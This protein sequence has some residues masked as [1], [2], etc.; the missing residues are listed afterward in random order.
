MAHGF[1]TPQAVSGESPISKYFEKKVDQLI[2]KGVKKIEN[3]AK[4]K[5]NQFKDLFSKKR[6]TTY[7]SGR[8][9]V[10]VAGR[11]GIGENTA[12]GGGILGGSPKV[13]GILPASGGLA[14]SQEN[15]IAT[16]GKNGTDLDNKFFRQKAL[17]TSDPEKPGNRPRK[18]GSYV[19]MGGM[20]SGDGLVNKTNELFSKYA[21]F[22]QEEVLQL[23]KE[24]KITASELRELK[25]TVQAQ[26]ASAAPSVSPDS[27]A[28]VVAAVN[29]NTE[30]IMRMVEVT[31]AQTS[32]DSSLVKEQIQAQE[33]MLSRSKARAEETQLEKGSD[34]SD[35]LKA[36]R[37]KKKEK[38]QGGGGGDD[39]LF[40]FL[41][42]A[43]DLFDFG[44]GGGKRKGRRGGGLAR[45]G[46]RRKAPPRIRAPRA[47]GGAPRI[48]T[49]KPSAPR[50]GVPK[51]GL[52]KIRGGPK[53][54]GALSLLFAGMEFSGRKSDGQSNIQAGLGT[55]ASV[56]GGIAGAKGGAAAGAAIG[57]LFGGVGAIPGGIIGGILGGIGGSMLAG[58]AADMAT[59]AFA[60]GG[61]ISK[62]I[63]SLMG[64]G[65]KKEGVFP[66]EGSEGK[67][68][69]QK[70]GEGIINA[71][72]DA[73][74][75]FSKIQ[76]AG[77]KFY[78]Q[79]QDGFKFFGD[80]LKN[81]FAPFLA[82][83]KALGALKD[84][85]GGLLNSLLGGAA[86]AA[87]RGPGG[88]MVD[89]TI[90]G[91]EEE[92]LMRLM[93][94]EAG[95]EGELGMAAVGRSVLNRA[96]LIQ[97]GEV[98]AGTFM[99]KS[100]SITDVIEGSGQ[101]QPF[102][103]GKLKRA[104]TQEERARAKKAL[105][106][107]RNQASLRANL[108]SSGMNSASINNIMAS[109]GF[110]TH[111]AR[112]DASQEVN[113]TELGGHRF[114]TAGN[115]K[116]LTPSANVSAGIS[117]K[118]GTGMATFGE[119]DGG[120]GRLRN[121]AGYVHGHFQSD[122][123]TRQDVVN[124][125]SEMVRGM[126]NSG[127]TDISISDGTTFK[128]SM[129]D[130]EIKALVERGLAQ[131]SHSGDGR[132]VDIFVPKGTPVP[133]PL[134]DVRTTGGGEGRNG[135]VPGSGKTWVGHLTP[136]SQSGSRPSAGIAAEPDTGG[137]GASP[138]SSPLA[139]NPLTAQQKS[140]MFQKAGMPAMSANTLTS[141][142]PISAA[143]ASPQTGTPI[144][145]TS[146]QVASASMHG[147]GP[148]V[149]NN[150]YGEGGGNKPT[151]VNP[152]G[153]T[154]GIGMEQT[155][156]AFLQDLSLRALG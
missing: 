109:T 152:N 117:A 9:G 126:L 94:A 77:L 23:I 33:T 85:G 21:G 68:T 143:P 24:R 153:V 27:G 13:K 88:G 50:P 14:K 66:L 7:R 115:A 90:S 99:S 140:Q 86:N 106:M 62:P 58:G 75:E 84:L 47:G 20:S 18:G 155:G 16:V 95:G 136:D 83:L 107:A 104:L 56:G 103:E 144:M 51:G 3:V 128:A 40:D 22:N 6:D 2:A 145:A 113:V 141:P 61:I 34:L 127:L 69:F 71:Q 29:K 78:F 12:K 37:F 4:N 45:R 148:T 19:N 93:I 146:A 48:R 63:L 44:G 28:D 92:Y 5:F 81:V 74:D 46:G 36:E 124:D 55:A 49:P 139:S 42:L 72:K 53:L 149:I 142:G 10:E 111:A 116:M 26:S 1:L 31:Q 32:N 132:S 87:Q 59:G 57:A 82:P 119:T 73:K 102:A 43:T 151:G 35:F 131:H 25:R 15:K 52:P 11:N 8:G 76:A 123:G 89:P 129:S 91:D 112:Y 79:N 100:G 156:T 96:G 137:S 133:F 130:G 121:Q 122:T 105:E 98:G 80:I 150:Y 60:N 41:D 110:R 30:A 97:S 65:N 39:S 125:T 135:I 147:A 138:P 17:P 134:T 118:E 101:Y 38:P 114:N 108:E 154:A 67:K 120:S 64:E 54:G 70:F